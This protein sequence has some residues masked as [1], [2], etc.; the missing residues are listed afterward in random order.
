MVRRKRTGELR[1][2]YIEETLALI[3]EKGGSMDVNLREISRRIG[4]AHTN[5]YNYFE[6]YDD[7]LWEAY[8]SGLR[9]YGAWIVK[10]LSQDLSGHEY[11]DG[12]MRNMFEFGLEN[13]GLHRFIS[14]DPF[15][16][17]DIPGD[18]IECVIDMKSYFN[19]AI[20]TMCLGRVTRE[21][22]DGIG[23]ILLGYM[24][25]ELFNIINGR[26]LP[27]EEAKE[28]VLTNLAMLFTLLTSKEHD[29]IVLERDAAKAGD[30][31]F[32]T[33]EVCFQPGVE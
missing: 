3:A 18:I 1:D 7:L 30:L 21:E 16:P 19:E 25:G 17:E 11:F 15:S 29:G 20:H 28:R 33:L 32:P 14:S 31:S 12:M 22:A 2:R 9:V 5:A 8:R 27:N 13:P 26:V 6:S 4:C 23:D 10:G 24:D